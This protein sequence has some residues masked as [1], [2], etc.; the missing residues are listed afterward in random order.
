MTLRDTGLI[1][2]VMAIWGFNFVTVKLGVMAFPPLFL[3][4]L[5]FALVAAL[6][7]PWVK[8]PRGQFLGVFGLSVT[9]GVAHF[10]LIFESLAGLDAATAAIAI[11]VQVP[12]SSLFAGLIDRDYLGW[13]RTGGMVLAF[14]GV[15]VIAGEPRV[16]ANLDSLAL[17]VLAS[18]MFAIASLQMRRLGA[19]SGFT[20]NGW[21]ALFAA[22]QL[23]VLSL[24]LET[25]Q[26][27]SL[28]TAPWEAWASLGYLVVVASITAYGLWFLLVRRYPI[29]RTAP[30]LLTLPIFG[31]A[32]GVLVLNEPFGPRLAIGAALTLAGV[33][34]IVFSRA[35]APDAGQPHTAPPPRRWRR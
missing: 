25:G 32:S 12:L 29:N 33:A 20:V 10:A 23:L 22:P 9:L 5:R 30:F 8:A 28:H 11:Q 24:F 14:A 26:L 6:L 4:V 17:L 34:T 18:S 1:L 21:M 19:I 27:E 7:V 15:V 13:H 35:P 31:S 3:M 2:S 16:T